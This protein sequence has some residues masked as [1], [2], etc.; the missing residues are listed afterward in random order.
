MPDTLVPPSITFAARGRGHST[1]G[2]ATWTDVLDATIDHGRTPPVLTDYVDLSVGGTL[3]VG[4]VGARTSAVG[5]QTDHVLELEVVTGAADTIV[6]S[7]THHADLFD[8][9]RA[10]L[11]QVAVITRATLRLAAAPRAVR[12]FLLFYASLPAMLADARRIADDDRFAS[13]QGAILPAPDG[14]GLSYRLDAVCERE[15]PDD[16]LLLAGLADD[17]RRRD[18]ATLPYREFAHRLD[19][20]EGALRGNGQRWFPHPW[21]MTFVGDENVERVVDAELRRLEP[22]VDLG[23]FGQVV[24]SP[25]R[26]AAITTPLLRVPADERVWAFNLVRI[27]ATDDADAAAR[28]VAANRAVLD[29]VVAA[30]GTLYPV[31]ALPFTPGEWRDHLGDAFARLAAAKRAYDPR[32]TLAPGY[33]VF[34]A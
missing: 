34:A 24:L 28:L 3:V 14:G 1:W 9:V 11:G 20:L 6:C 17:P 30:G 8:A 32:R 22:G 10:G 27:P 5:V 26:R 12:R 13:V 4:G 2:C 25:L 18:V 29:R 7:P 19:A 23:P 16:D 31:S 33:E 21:L 15:D